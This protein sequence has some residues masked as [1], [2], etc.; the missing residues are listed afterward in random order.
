[1]SEKQM[2][3]AVDAY[4]NYYKQLFPDDKLKLKVSD[5]KY[6]PVKASEWEA[7]LEKYNKEWGARKVSQMIFGS[8]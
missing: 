1:M 4:N 5:F 8:P 7:I 2:Q 6:D 3:T